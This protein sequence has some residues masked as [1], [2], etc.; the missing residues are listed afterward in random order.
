MSTNDLKTQSKKTYLYY[1]LLFFLFCTCYACLTY[2]T[3][4]YWRSGCPT[5]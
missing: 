4:Y 5:R 1:S 2:N 3:A